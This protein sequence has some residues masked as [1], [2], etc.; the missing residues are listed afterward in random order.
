MRETLIYLA[1]LDHDD[2]EKQVF[3]PEN[4]APFFFAGKTITLY[5]VFLISFKFIVE[6]LVQK[7]LLLGNLYCLNMRRFIICQ[8]MKPQYQLSLN[9]VL[10]A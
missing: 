5:G 7:K 10:M 4:T 9:M 6:R 2:T 1:H 8:I 3:E